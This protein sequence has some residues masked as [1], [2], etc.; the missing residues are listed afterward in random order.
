MTNSERHQLYLIAWQGAAL[1]P[2][3][4]DSDAVNGLLSQGCIVE[5]DGKYLLTPQGSEA[6][7]SDSALKA[8]QRPK[9]FYQR[10]AEEQ[11]AI[12][13]ELGISDWDGT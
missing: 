13:E 6:A 12:D 4:L 9:D 3:R 1:D 7:L 2:A 8:L 10:T 5:V 11:C